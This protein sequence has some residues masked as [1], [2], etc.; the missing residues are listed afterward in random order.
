MAIAWL[1]ALAATGCSP[2]H[3]ETGE[4][5]PAEA[6]SPRLDGLPG[7]LGKLF[8]DSRCCERVRLE[9]IAARAQK[10]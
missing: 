8:A 9:M 10:S 3:A 6:K 2:A 7:L 1:L 5:A 4:K